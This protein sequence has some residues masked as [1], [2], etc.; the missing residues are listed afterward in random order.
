MEIVLMLLADKVRGSRLWFI[1]LQHN[2]SDFSFCTR[3]TVDISCSLTTIS[4]VIR[5]IPS[6]LAS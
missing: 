6:E 1:N 2:M 5:A 3:P 4:S